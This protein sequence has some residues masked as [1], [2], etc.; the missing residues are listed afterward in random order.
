MPRQRR[1][2]SLVNPDRRCRRCC[3]ACCLRRARNAVAARRRYH[4]SGRGYAAIAV[5]ACRERRVAAHARDAAVQNATVAAR[6]AMPRMSSLRCRHVF[7]DATV[8]TMRHV[9]T[10]YLHAAPTWQA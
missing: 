6:P 8:A 4:G 1:N 3:P 9:L 2:A 10:Y 7:V 5:A